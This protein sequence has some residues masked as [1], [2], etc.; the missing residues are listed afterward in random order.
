MAEEPQND[1]HVNSSERSDSVASFSG[2]RNSI[3]R[4]GYRRNGGR[5]HRYRR[6]D[7]P[8]KMTKGFSVPP[9]SLPEKHE[10]L[11]Y[12][13]PSGLLLPPIPV[14]GF[15]LPP[16]QEVGQ[17]DICTPPYHVLDVWGDRGLFLMPGHIPVE[18]LAEIGL[19]IPMFWMHSSSISPNNR[20]RAQWKFKLNVSDVY[21]LARVFLPNIFLIVVY[22]SWRH[23]QKSRL[24]VVVRWWDARSNQL[25]SLDVC[26]PVY[27]RVEYRAY[28]T[29]L[30]I[31]RNVIL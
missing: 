10:S 19:V 7:G 11:P 3:R 6:E 2:N 26:L 29:E 24:V 21:W 16:V 17:K 13:L 9:K 25:S 1:V 23:I 20:I 31:V 14:C 8:S 4:N 30:H 15:T 28:C 27:G 12:V 22:S 18:S 5:K